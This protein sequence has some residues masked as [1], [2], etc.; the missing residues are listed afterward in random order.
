[1]LQDNAAQ[2]GIANRLLATPCWIG[3]TV[4]LELWWVLTTAGRFLATGAAD[5][6]QA[7]A[8]METVTLEH[9]EPVIWAA[10]RAAEGADFADMLHL[11]LSAG[12]DCFATFDKS[13]ARHTENSPVPVETL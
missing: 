12:S 13:I 6:L 3:I 11:A 9:S 4:T 8:A 7:I 10:Q 1:M 5:A 2:A